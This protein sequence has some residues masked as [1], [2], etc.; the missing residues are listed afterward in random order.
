MTVRRQQSFADH[1]PGAGDACAQTWWLLRESYF[2]NAVDVADGIAITSEDTGWH[3]LLLL[4]LFDLCVQF[5]HLLLQFTIPWRRVVVDD[6]TGTQQ[7]HNTGHGLYQPRPAFS[8]RV[9]LLIWVF[10]SHSHPILPALAGGIATG[11]ELE[12]GLSSRQQRIS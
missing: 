8:H 9:L 7:D 12:L 6:D 11:Q 3:V 4:E 5:A 10:V 1:E 2:V